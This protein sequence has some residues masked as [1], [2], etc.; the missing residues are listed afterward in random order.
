[1]HSLSD[2][3]LYEADRVPPLAVSVSQAQLSSAG[4]SGSHSSEC[5]DGSLL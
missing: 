1:M 3:E 4:I 2:R 5:E